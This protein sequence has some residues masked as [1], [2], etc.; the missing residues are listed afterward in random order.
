MRCFTRKVAGTLFSHSCHNG[1]FCSSLKIHTH[2]KESFFKRNAVPAYVNNWFSYLSSSQVRVTHLCT[3][4][5]HPKEMATH[6]RAL[7]WRIPWMEEP[8]GLH[9][10]HGVAKSRTRLSVFTYT[11]WCQV[12]LSKGFSRQEYWSGL[13][14]SPPADLCNPGIELMTL[15]HWIPK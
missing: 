4:L 12:P 2:K 13:P 3:T 9:T 7:A 8:G 14:C 11:V 10:V 5:C 1:L 6:S 15:M